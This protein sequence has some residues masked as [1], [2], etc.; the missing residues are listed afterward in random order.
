MS[1]I[2]DFFAKLFAQNGS[3]SNVTVHGSFSGS[4]IKKHLTE[5][6]GSVVKHPIEFNQ[7]KAITINGCF[8]TT[9][10]QGS[11]PSAHL[12]INENLIP[13]LKVKMMNGEWCIQIDK[14]VL[15]NPVLSLTITTPHVDS[16]HYNGSGSLDIQNFT[17]EIMTIVKSGSANTLFSGN[18]GKLSLNLKGSGNFEGNFSAQYTDIR[19]DNSGDCDITAAIDKPVFNIDGT[20]KF[21]F[22]G[23]HSDIVKIKKSSV[24][25]CSFSGSCN[26]LNVDASSVGDLNM[27]EFKAQHVVFE[28]T[29]VGTLKCNAAQS[30]SGFSDGVGSVHVFGNPN[31]KEVIKKGVG[32]LIYR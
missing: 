5:D 28:H 30:I 27:A 23:S 15:I 3:I 18:F 32:D 14:P 24:G 21:I 8:K 16:I 19:K 10:K 17:Q 20:G 26:K 1:I 9:I 13:F 4:D 11:E 2:S 12:E 22:V 29:G 6:N 7:C 25:K 31:K